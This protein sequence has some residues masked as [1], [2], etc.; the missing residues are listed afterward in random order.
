MKHNRML[1]KVLFVLLAAL[2]VLACGAGSLRATATPVPTN[3]PAATNTPL[4][5]NTPAATNTPLPP[6]TETEI[7]ATPTPVPMGTPVS[8]GDYEVNVIFMRTLDTVYLDAQYQWVPSAGNMFVELGIKVV[9]LKP[10]SNVS[11]SWGDI[12]VI[13][14]DGSIWYPGWGESKSAVSGVEIS[15]KSLVFRSLDN[16]DEQIVFD[17]VVFVRAIYGV[18]K[19]SPTTILFGFGDA[20]LI[21]VVV[22]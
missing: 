17:E 5:T 11:V 13:E 7:P 6:P 9:N 16:P 18:A 8:S 14:E 22:P 4:P 15:P 3:T 2:F 10:G 12:Y 21:E 1:T 20:P 19:H